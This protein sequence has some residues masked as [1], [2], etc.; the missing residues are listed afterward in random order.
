MNLI[1][2][3][4]HKVRFLC[5]FTSLGVL[6]ISVGFYVLTVSTKCDHQGSPM[7]HYVTLHVVLY[8]VRSILYLENGRLVTHSRVWC[9][10][11]VGNAIFGLCLAREI[12]AVV[13]PMLLEHFGRKRKCSLQSSSWS[14][15]YQILHMT[16]TPPLRLRP[17]SS[18]HSPPHEY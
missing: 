12:K 13:I 16:I 11:L 5:V 3:I 14:S 2:L 18:P 10:V 1:L 9:Q 8:D 15:G 17:N 7:H 6:V 4:K